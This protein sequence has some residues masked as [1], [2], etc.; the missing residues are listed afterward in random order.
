MMNKARHQARS[1]AELNRTKVLLTALTIY[2]GE[3]GGLYPEE[4]LH[5]LVPDYLEDRADLKTA[6]GADYHFIGGFTDA[7]KGN[8]VILHTPVN[9]L[10]GRHIIGRLN[11]A[12]EVVSTEELQAILRSQKVE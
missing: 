12:A 10:P 6:T 8:S 7:A 2:A 4:G 11:G 5:E 9:G 3:Y 1:V